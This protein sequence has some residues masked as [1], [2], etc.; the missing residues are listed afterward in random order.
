M[1]ESRFY[2]FKFGS[3]FGF[4]ALAFLCFALLGYGINTIYGGGETFYGVVC[5]IGGLIC[6]GLAAWS[7]IRWDKKE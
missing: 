4:V 7:Y 1:A 2:W 5:I 6:G 3:V